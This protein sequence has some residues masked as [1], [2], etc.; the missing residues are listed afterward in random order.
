MDR[1][2][3]EQLFHTKNTAICHVL[4][5]LCIRATLSLIAMISRP[6]SLPAL[7]PMVFL[8]S[9]QPTHHVSSPHQHR[10]AERAALPQLAAALILT[11]KGPSRPHLA[12]LAALTAP[13][14]MYYGCP[15]HK[16]LLLIGGY[17]AQKG[18]LMMI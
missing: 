18:P 2:E 5:R 16:S 8:T 10:Q 9:S 15:L 7:V 6:P 13:L 17:E 3:R 11:D 4:S 14:T 12:K 1:A